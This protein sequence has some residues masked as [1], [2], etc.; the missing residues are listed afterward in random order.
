MIPT[1]SFS[2]RVVALPETRELD[3]LAELLEG[4]GAR[5]WRCPMVAILDAPDPAPSESWLHLLVAG[6]MDDVILLTGEGLRRLMGVA[7]RLSI[8]A[9]VTIAL[10]RVRKITR[11]PKPARA[12]K[13]LGLPTDLPAAVPTSVGI[14]DELRALDLRGR[15]VGVQLYGAEPSRD[16]CA[17]IEA[18]G[19][20]VF[21]VAP[22][23][24]AA[25]SDLA[26]VV[27]L[28]AEMSAGRVDVI[29]FTSASQ[30]ERLFEVAR[31]QKLEPTLAQ[32]LSLTRVAAIGPIAAEALRRHGVQPAIVPE[33]AYVMKRL[34]SAIVAALT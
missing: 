21:P 8:A 10:G 28:I 30:I 15:R 25:A 32:G 1:N 6:G 26:Q 9:E 22:Y 19:A 34:V 17:F 5:A 13:D 4:E 14:M 27:E 31:A 33:K 23:I 16:L 20:T 11:G 29:A 7:D 24:Y 2:G 3:R 18:A 12:L